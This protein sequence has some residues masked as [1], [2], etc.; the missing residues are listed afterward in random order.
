VK[1]QKKKSLNTIPACSLQF[2]FNIITAAALQQSHPL[3]LCTSNLYGKGFAFIMYDTV[4]PE[5]YL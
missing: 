1:P 5:G 2:H 3:L 4:C